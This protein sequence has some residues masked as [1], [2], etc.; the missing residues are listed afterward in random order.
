MS[1][2]EIQRF[3][4]G[5]NVFITGATGFLGKIL[6]EKLL[7][8]C[9][10][11]N[12]V[13]ILMRPKPGMSIKERVEKLIDGN[14]FDV[15]KEQTPFYREK[16]IGISGNCDADCLDMSAADRE[17]I[18]REVSIIFHSAANVK[19]T[20][21][22]EL[23]IRTN[24]F[25]V[26]NIIDF[27]RECKKLR[28]IVYVSTAYSYCTQDCIKEQHYVPP[29]TL[30]ECYQLIN[31]MKKRELTGQNLAQM[32][33]Y[34]I[35]KWPNTYTFTKAI[36]EGVV[37]QYGQG[38]P[39][40][41]FRPSIMGTTLNEPA[42]GWTDN[43][44]GFNFLGVA[45]FKGI[46][47]A[48]LFKEHV[49]CDLIPS[50]LTINALIA[51][52]YDASTVKPKEKKTAEIPVYN[53]VSSAQN[54]ITW[55][56]YV[57]A[58]VDIGMTLP[59]KSSLFYSFVINTPYMPVFVVL[60]FFLHFLPALL[61]E[62]VGRLMG[63]KLGTYRMYKAMSITSDALMYFIQRDWTFED[64]QIQRIW[65]ELNDK[66]KTLFPFDISSLDWYEYAHTHTVGVRK[67]N[68]REEMDTLPEGKARHQRLFYVFVAMLI[69]IFLS[70]AWLL[71]TFFRL[72]S[73]LLGF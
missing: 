41:I 49:K 38:L 42:K 8:S 11:I 5:Q 23:A 60:D 39:I 47:H 12:K 53:Y 62:G 43:L 6:L 69:V 22:L 68:V 51:C 13:Y 29:L 50:D 35:G 52:A 26:K 71:W 25:A 24:I 36:A 14:I 21:P 28:V 44:N 20:N 7:R 18:T 3:F 45:A 57:S 48:M 33:Q 37:A 31:I 58:T 67:Y 40:A 46:V 54:P 4:N 1:E 70:F 17:L 59:I 56:K 34:I 9:P 64:K 66:D 32:S 55:K 61:V 15:L 10:K 2:S 73:W 63:K 65:N 27:S 19:F 16:V 30:E 72:T